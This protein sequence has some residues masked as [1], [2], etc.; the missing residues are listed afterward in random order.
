MFLKIEETYEIDLR[1]KVYAINLKV[2]GGGVTL[3]FSK[4]MYCLTLSHYYLRRVKSFE[5]CARYPSV[6]VR[7]V[8]RLLEVLKI[9]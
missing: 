6:A 4:H 1:G 2:E 3:N 7:R 8:F 9:F 5:S